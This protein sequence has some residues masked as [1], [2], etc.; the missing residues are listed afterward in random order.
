MSAEVLLLQTREAKTPPKHRYKVLK[1]DTSSRGFTLEILPLAPPWCKSNKSL[2][3][4]HLQ[5][6]GFENPEYE[7]YFR[8]S[9]PSK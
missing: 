9:Y 5:Q 4:P 8:K 7:V 1:E 3:L 6:H 2:L